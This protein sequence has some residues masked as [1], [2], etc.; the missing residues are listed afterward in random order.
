MKMMRY[1]IKN[2]YFYLFLYIYIYI[3]HIFARLTKIHVFITVTAHYTYFALRLAT[4]YSSTTSAGN[5]W[6]HVKYVQS[7]LVLEIVTYIAH[8]RYAHVCLVSDHTVYD[9]S[10]KIVEYKVFLVIAAQF[11]VWVVLPVWTLC[12]TRI[13]H[14]MFRWSLIRW[15]WLF[16][17]ELTL[18]KLLKSLRSVLS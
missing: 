10:F 18:Q 1:N 8:V 7:V 11:F 4:F 2:V 5:V 16:S 15:D 12:N 3:I 6:I 17:L 14:T 13:A 9:I